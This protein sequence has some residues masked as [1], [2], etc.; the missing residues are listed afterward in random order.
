MGTLNLIHFGKAPAGA[1]GRLGELSFVSPYFVPLF[2]EFFLMVGL[3]CRSRKSE[4]LVGP[5]RQL[6]SPQG[7]FQET[8]PHQE[9]LV[10]RFDGV[11]FLVDRGGDGGDPDRPAPGV[12]DN[13][14]ENLA[15]HFV[16]PARA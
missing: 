9:R 3:S 14:G 10:D 7:S 5:R 15:V 11:L 16:Q 2:K 1:V 6:P 12:P 13:G 8:D 4:M